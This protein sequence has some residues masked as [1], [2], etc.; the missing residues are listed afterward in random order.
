LKTISRVALLVAAVAIAGCASTGTTTPPAASSPAPAPAPAAATVAAPGP[1]L[2]TL[3]VSVDCGACEVDPAVPAKIVESYSATAAKAGR[4]VTAA[5]EAKLVIK[6]YSARNG[7][8]R[9]FAG[10]MAGKD[11]IKAVITYQ[12]KTY[13]VEEYY[14]NAWMG[15]TAVAEKIGEMSFNELK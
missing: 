6:D 14:R 7:A 11:E 13:S 8:A 9:F 5:K 3:K 2:P 4:K 1:D 10:A 15:I 12:G